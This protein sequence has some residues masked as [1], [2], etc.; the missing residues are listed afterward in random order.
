MNPTPY[1]QLGSDA[2]VRALAEAFYD[3][4][5]ELPEA[6]R[7]RSLHAASLDGVK[8]KFADYLS[9]WLGGPHHYFAKHGQFCIRSA[10]ERFRIGTEERD[11]WLRCMDEALLRVQAPPE[12]I[13]QLRTPLY[14]L[15]DAMRTDQG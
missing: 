4:M 10:H 7:I 15:A 6:R 9:G 3:I 5:D 2:G 14:R 8:G 13:Q 1:E 12:L 11:Q